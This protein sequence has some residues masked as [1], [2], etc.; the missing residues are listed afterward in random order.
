V[1]TPSVDTESTV[2]PSAIRSSLLVYW[3]VGARSTLDSP[4]PV[5]DASGERYIFSVPRQF[6]RLSAP[7]P[8][9]AKVVRTNV[10]AKR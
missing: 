8:G 10:R 2:L 1:S 9:P 5:M 7:P 3:R 6:K 4:G